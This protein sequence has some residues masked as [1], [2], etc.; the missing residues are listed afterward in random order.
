MAQYSR[1]GLRFVFLQ[2]TLA[3]LCLPGT[4]D[5]LWGQPPDQ[6]DVPLSQPTGND[7]TSGTTSMQEL[8]IWIAKQ[9]IPTTYEERK[10]WGKKREIVTGLRLV[11]SGRKLRTAA[12]RKMVNHGTWKMYRVTLKD[13][14]DNFHIEL[15]R[16][17]VT[18][19]NR[20]TFEAIIE[21]RLDMFARW[22]Q[23]NRGVQLISLNASAD[24]EVRLQLT[25]NM[26]IHIDPG[27]LPPDI[28]VIPEVTSADLQVKS[29]RLR[30]ISQ[31]HG[32]LAHK[33]GD[34]ALK[35]IQKKLA[36]KR[37]DLVKKMNRQIK[38]NEGKLRLSFR[39]VLQQGWGRLMSGLQEKTLR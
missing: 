31:L 8:L 11:G 9:S 14:Q 19:D 26:A 27:K 7:T 37:P 2:T 24:A 23:W 16:M 30:R 12:R 25:G 35:I 6:A 20:L 5:V 22:A 3:L 21:A 13:R 33:I 36:E 1:F 32:S 39:E 34:E 4:G 38:K 28:A 10:D 17:Q 18:D 29:F 15:N